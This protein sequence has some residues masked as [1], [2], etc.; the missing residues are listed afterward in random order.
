VATCLV[1]HWWLG[2]IDGVHHKIN[3]VRYLKHNKIEAKERGGQRREDGLL[4][5][6][7]RSLAE[8]MLRTQTQRETEHLQA[9]DSPAV[10]TPRG[11]VL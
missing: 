8:A 7:P 5:V 3:N 1:S 6:T 10:I 4:S 11:S 2:K 9:P